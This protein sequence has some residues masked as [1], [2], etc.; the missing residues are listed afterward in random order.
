L[1]FLKSRLQAGRT[2]QG[3]NCLP[4][5]HE[6]LSSIPST[7]K[8]KKKRLCIIHQY[9][10]TEKTTYTY[11]SSQKNKCMSS[12]H[13]QTLDQG[14]TQLRGLDFNYVIKREHSWEV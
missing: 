2:A 4:S 14:Q 12:P 9:I 11:I 5:K 13:M 10:I 3:T 7:A 6:A 1:V 8:K